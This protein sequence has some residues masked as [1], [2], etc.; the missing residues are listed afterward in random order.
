MVPPYPRSYVTLPPAFLLI[1]GLATLCWI[2][3]HTLLWWD[4]LV[5]WDLLPS[6][7]ALWQVGYSIALTQFSTGWL[8][9][10]PALGLPCLASSDAS[11]AFALAVRAVPAARYLRVLPDDAL[12]L[13]WRRVPYC[14]VVPRRAFRAAA[15]SNAFIA[16]YAR[17][18]GSPWIMPLLLKYQPSHAALRRPSAASN[19]W[20]RLRLP[21]YCL[22][23]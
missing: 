23:I 9:A 8:D 20:Q 13:C 3:L 10:L 16:T 7:N 12:Y 6:S 14:I 19:A 15:S 1:L 2:A 17:L 4:C 18:L 11:R 22:Y 5:S 21:P